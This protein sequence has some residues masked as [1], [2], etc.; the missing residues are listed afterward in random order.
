MS[1]RWCYM[2]RKGIEELHDK[3]GYDDHYTREFEEYL[4]KG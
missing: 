2:K 1:G 4:E 3:Q